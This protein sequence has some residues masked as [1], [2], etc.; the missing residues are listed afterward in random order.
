MLLSHI[1]LMNTIREYVRNIRT[2]TSIL[3][4]WSLAISFD[5]RVEQRAPLFCYKFFFPS[6]LA[7]TQL[8]VEH[9]S[10]I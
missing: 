5:N 3:G 4:K 2:S 7:I 6:L 9:F 1:E 10:M 8:L